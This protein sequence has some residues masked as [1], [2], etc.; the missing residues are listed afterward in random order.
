MGP[1]SYVSKAGFWMK[2]SSSVRKRIEVL[3]TLENFIT[4]VQELKREL[5]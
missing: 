3:T 4:T 5:S 1:S 2:R